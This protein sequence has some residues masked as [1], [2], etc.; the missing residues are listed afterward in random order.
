MVKIKL[1]KEAIL[2]ENEWC[3]LQIELSNLSDEGRL[4]I[5]EN[6]DHEIYLDRPDV[7]IHNLKTLI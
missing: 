1:K 3:K 6:S 4:I 5:A 7:I 2:Y